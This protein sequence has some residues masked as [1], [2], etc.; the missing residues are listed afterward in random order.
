M[1][2]VRLE[3][4]PLPGALVTL[5]L[6]RVSRR[7]LT[8]AGLALAVALVTQVFGFDLAYSQ[9][10]S[11]TVW[12][13]DDDPGID[14]NWTGWNDV[15]TARVPLTA[16][17][18]TA[19]MGGGT[20]P[21]VSVQT[22]HYDD[23]LVVR[24]GWR[25]AT[26]DT[27]TDKPETFADAVAIQ[28]P[29]TASSSVPA[30]C[31]GQA[32]ASVNIWHWRAD[33]QAGV[34]SVPETDGYVD[35]YPDTSETYYPA[36]AS[37]NP[38]ASA[39]PVQNL[40]VGGFGTLTP[41]LE[42]TVVGEG[43]YADGAWTVVLRRSFAAPGAEQPQFAVGQDIDV[44]LAAWNGSRD[45]RDGIKSVSQFVRFTITDSPVPAPAD[46]GS[47]TA[48]ASPSAVGYVLVGAFAGAVLVSLLVALIWF[49]VVVKS[50]RDDD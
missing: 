38:F 39:A 18:V 7:M 25:D 46:S 19:P 42:Q 50:V 49:G 40:L 13:A 1:R 28:F 5:P 2:T 31:M 17:Q 48:A 32:D 14:P 22:V 47:G 12:A 23:D 8:I 4:G 29:A 43:Q 33:S 41:A 24:I 16:Q 37:G 21:L 27:S 15:P 3:A 34:A 6:T 35:F 10:L 44:A 20:T 26:E 36:A 9:T 45:E 30:I 11:V